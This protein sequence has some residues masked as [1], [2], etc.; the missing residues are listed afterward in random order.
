VKNGWFQ[1]RITFSAAKQY[2]ITVTAKDQA[3][4]SSSVVRNVIYRPLKSDDRKHRE[5]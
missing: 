4:N 5:D 1:Q 3:G 2:T